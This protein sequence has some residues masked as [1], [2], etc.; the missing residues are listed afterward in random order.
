MT[1][2]LVALS[3]RV[4]S[5]TSRQTRIINSFL[6][7]Q[8]PPTIAE[9]SQVSIIE[10]QRII[11]QFLRRATTDMVKNHS[12][13]VAIQLEKLRLIEEAA[14]SA[15]EASR[16]DEEIEE[17]SQMVTRFNDPAGGVDQ[18][19]A[20]KKKKNRKRD[21]TAQFL[22]IVFNAIQERSR[23]LNLYRDVTQDTVG[24]TL[25]EYLEDTESL[26]FSSYEQIDELAAFEDAVKSFVV[27]V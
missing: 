23:L 15:W 13:N 3:D 16:L 2:I 12:E 24:A 19:R 14:W 5:T 21:G 11:K 27:N 1:D 9:L 26:D 22:S 18:Q 8:T 6:K 7:G 20:L 10:V 4:V 25:D 17:T